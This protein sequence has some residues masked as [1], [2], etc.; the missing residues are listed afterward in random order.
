MPVNS[1]NVANLEKPTGLEH[2]PTL[3]P[4]GGMADASDLKARA[5]IAVSADKSNRLQ[6]G[7]NLSD[8]EKAAKRR[9][10]MFSDR[11]VSC[12][13]CGG[14]FRPYVRQL[15]RNAGMF[16]SEPCRKRFRR[17][18]L[19]HDFVTPQSSKTERTRAQGLINMRIRRGTLSRP[20]A[21][22]HCGTP[23]KTDGHHP[24]YAQA[25]LIVFLC[26]SCHMK[27]HRSPE[28]EREVAAKAQS[29]GGKFHPVRSKAVAN[30]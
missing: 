26:R 14:S 6:A 10:G 7:G 13:Q 5:S 27:A 12:D 16:C 23:A 25:E 22:Q 8:Q 24:D 2:N 28:F 18:A 29:T 15:Y 9:S 21:C 11:E 3:G 1:Q 19:H 20:D 30:V 4:R 17:A